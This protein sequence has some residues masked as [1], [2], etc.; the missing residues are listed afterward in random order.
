M[1]D[2]H[3]WIIHSMTAR[4][5]HTGSQCAGQRGACPGWTRWCFHQVLHALLIIVRWTDKLFPVCLDII[6]F[7]CRIFASFLAIAVTC[8]LQFLPDQHLWPHHLWGL[9]Q[10]CSEAHQAGALYFP[11]LVVTFMAS[12]YNLDSCRLWR[13]Y[14][15]CWTRYGQLIN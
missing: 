9:Q 11:L 5:D 4:R 3:Q 7:Y 1:H 12:S 13:T 8:G 10:G 14:W 2:H 15:T 6:S